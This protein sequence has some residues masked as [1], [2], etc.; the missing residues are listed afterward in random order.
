MLLLVAAVLLI[1]AQTTPA[2]RPADVLVETSGGGTGRTPAFTAHG[3]FTLTYQFEC[4]TAIGRGGFG[5]T[6]S[7][8][9][10]IRDPG[11]ADAFD[12]QGVFDQ[13]SAGT[14]SRVYPS[15][16]RFYIDIGSECD[17]HVSVVK[18]SHAS[19]TPAG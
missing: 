18:G 14:N 16:G 2:Q 9:A 1:R 4:S 19:R 8:E 7:F 13:G 6:G 17:W 11:G 3:P 10:T 15:G 12:G 5:T